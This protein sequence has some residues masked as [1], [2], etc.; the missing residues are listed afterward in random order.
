MVEIA[1]QKELRDS[2]LVRKTVNVGLTLN[3]EVELDSLGDVEDIKKI[4]SERFNVKI[5]IDSSS[6]EDHLKVK[7]TTFAGVEVI[8]LLDEVA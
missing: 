2:Q 8:S 5:G 4:I 6:R 1:K 7:E 3:L